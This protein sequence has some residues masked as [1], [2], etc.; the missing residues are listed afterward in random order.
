MKIFNWIY[1]Y[2]DERKNLRQKKDYENGYS[3]A[4]FRIIYEGKTP[5]EVESLIW[6]QD[7]THFDI[8]IKDAIDECVERNIV[9][10]DRF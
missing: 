4:L 9:K 2:L 10:E 7:I 3:L 6:P 8:G 5:L 1:Q